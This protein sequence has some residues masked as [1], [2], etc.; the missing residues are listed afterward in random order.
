MRDANVPEREGSAPDYTA[1]MRKMTCGRLK[2][3]VPMIAVCNSTPFDSLSEDQ[4]TYLLRD[5]GSS[6]RFKEEMD[7]GHRPGFEASITF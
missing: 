3:V 7:K 4:S 5:C 1:K 6:L 2:S